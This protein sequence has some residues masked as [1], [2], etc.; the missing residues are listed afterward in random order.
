MS[1]G[2][3]PNHS[4]Q[5]MSSYGFSRALPEGLEGLTALALDLRWTW[6]HF[7]DRLWQQLDPE[8]W[9]RTGNPY[10]ILQSISLSRLE[11]AARDQRLKEDLHNWLVQRQRYLDDPGWYGLDEAHAQIRGIAYFSMEFGL[12]EALPIYSGGLGILAGDHLK[13][14][15]DLGVNLVGVGLLYQQGYFRQSLGGDAWQVEAYPYND[16]VSLPLVPVQQDDGGWLRIRLELPGRSLLLRAWQAQVGKVTLYLLD[17]NDPLN[18]PRDRGITAN[19]YPA[20]QEQRLMQEIVLGVGG[21]RLLEAL[22]RTIDVCHL[23]EGHAAFAI[24]ARVR[25]F[26]VR[27]GKSFPDALCATRAGNVFTTHTPVE[28][29]FDRFDPSLIRPYARHLSEMVRV[30]EEELLALGRKNPNN[31]HEPFNMAYLALR[32]CGFVNGVSRLHSR[33]SRRIFQDLFPSWP[34][35]EVPVHAITNGVHVPSWDSQHAD[36]LWTKLCGKGRWVGT[37]EEVCPLFTHVGD[38]ELWEFRV[39]Q[40]N[41]LVHYVR[42]RLVRQYQEHGEPDHVIQL[43]QHVL[44][45]NALTLGFARRFTSYKRP[46]LLLY[47]RERLVN[48]L[49]DPERPVQLIVAGKAHP[50]DDE[51]KRLVQAMAQFAQTPQCRERVVFLEDYEMGLAQELVAGVDVWVNTPRRPWEACGTSGMKVLVNGGLNLSELDG[52][53][54]EAYAPELG[55]AIGD[56]EDHDEAGW[57]QVEADQ[58]HDI[59]EQQIIREFYARDRNGIPTRWVERIRSSMSRLTPEF[60]SNRM[61]REYVDRAYVIAAQAYRQRASDDAKLAGELL[62]WKQKLADN[63]HGLRFGRQSAARVG[64]AWQFE[65]EVYLGDLDPSWVSVELYADGEEASSR[66]IPMQRKAALPGLVNAHLYHGTATAARPVGHYTP[67]IVPFHP[68]AAVPLEASQIF[69]R[70]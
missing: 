59:L 46:T 47:N 8:A 21:W 40:R 26:M 44:D 3:K 4:H 41:S 43:A 57:D 7:C 67:R 68:D 39:A 19:L 29:A 55:W 62:D 42:R 53:W 66:R 49:S 33:V 1:E 69:W 36:A 9:E 60:S 31:Q 30:P 56:G 20:A 38:K 23:N 48:L 27:T 13:A 52:W 11:E 50:K 61:V 70:S 65:V 2:G 28:A 35:S 16:P 34:P 5:G 64:E 18:S 58:L 22:G 32:G 37:M 25:S 63:W 54:A 6:S 12:G 15:S 24:V 51:G 45:P 14:A 10:L 17:S